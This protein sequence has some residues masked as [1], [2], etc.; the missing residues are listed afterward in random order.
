M[1]RSVRGAFVAAILI[2]LIDTLGRSLVTDGL[3]VVADA[4]TANTVGPALASMLIYIMMAAILAFRPEGLFPA[5]GA[6]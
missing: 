2:G 4:S 1:Y 3:R 5:A 6:R